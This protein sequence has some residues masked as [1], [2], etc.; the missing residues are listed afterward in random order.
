MK[1]LRLIV[2][3]LAMT[4]GASSGAQT[5]TPGDE[6]SS[7]D[8]R[9]QTT[10]QPEVSVQP[11]KLVREVVYNELHDHEGHGYW[12]YWIERKTP[13][14]TRLENQIETAQGPVTR[15]AKSNGKPVST[16]TQHLEEAR[17]KHL[18]S[19]PDEQARHFRDYKEDEDRIGHMVSLMPDAYVYQYA[20]EENGC[21]KLNFTPNP[22]YPAHSIEARVVH[23]MSGT[24]W[25]DARMKRMARLDAHINENLDFGFGL[26]GRLYKGG[27]FRIERTQVSATDWKTQRL[28]VHIAGRAL[29]VKSFAR[30]TS[31]IRGGFV[32]VP[33]GMNLA[34][35]MAMLE[36]TEA[37]SQLVSKPE[38]KTLAK[39]GALALRR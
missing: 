4:L 27:W 35:G 18:L 32:A 38:V 28:E 13:K 8:S 25:V 39:P 6:A 12:R 36:Q 9:T 14:E 31:E 30:E 22:K 21:H 17:L 3:I 19:S 7:I 2:G 1:V 15:L 5:G 10:E 23:S 26:F 20:G 34:Q 29:I 24:L 37:Q 11:L 16:E 33:A